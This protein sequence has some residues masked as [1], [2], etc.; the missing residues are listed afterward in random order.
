MGDPLESGEWN[1]KG[2][3]TR[4]RVMPETN[5]G[6]LA[7]HETNMTGQI[8]PTTPNVFLQSSNMCAFHFI[9]APTPLALPLD[10]LKLPKVR[11]KAKDSLKEKQ[12]N[13]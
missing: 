11:R 6:G 10:H 8:F 7:N 9:W 5:F 1:L 4:P 13:P 3:T 12:E 2:C